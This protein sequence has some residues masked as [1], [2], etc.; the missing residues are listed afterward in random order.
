MKCPKEI[1]LIIIFFKINVS[2]KIARNVSPPPNK[3]HLK[4]FISPEKLLKT[5]RTLSPSQ[6]CEI[7]KL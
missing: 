3:L 2:F 6:I 5:G 7:P 4:S 1:P